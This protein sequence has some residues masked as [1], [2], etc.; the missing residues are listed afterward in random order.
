MSIFITE[1]IKEMNSYLESQQQSKKIVYVDMDG[2]LCDFDKAKAEALAKQPDI[3]HPQCQM[4]FFRSLPLIHG[5]DIA[6]EGLM[7][8]ERVDVYI[9]S[10]PS[11]KN[12]M[13]YTE[14]FLWLKDHFGEEVARRL[15]LS[16]F[17]N[18]NKGDYLIDDRIA[19]GSGE[20]EGEL[21]HFGSE[22]FPDWLTTLKYL[23]NE[24]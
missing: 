2:V 16:K 15:I 7:G 8:D 21:I 13:S 5:A 18:L 23:D 24:L 14:K 4:D 11:Y 6:L 1:L 9:L 19:N 12:P 10:S 22:K 17:K 20:F 3:A